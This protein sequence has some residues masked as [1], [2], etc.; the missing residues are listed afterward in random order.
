M[1]LGVVANPR[2]G[3]LPSVLNR[4]DRLATNHGFTLH[5]EESIRSL[6]SRDIP[7]LDEGDLGALVTLGGDGTL[8]RGSRLLE[9]WEIPILGVNVGRLGFLTTVRLG[10]LEE[11]L[12]A[13]RAGTYSVERRMMLSGSIVG[14]D[15]A[16]RGQHVALNDIA[17]HKSGVARV[18]RLR[19]WIEEEEIGP[20]SGDGLVIATPTG[21]TAY[22]LSAG[23]PI[24]VPGVEG[25]VV[26]PICAHTMAVRPLVV[27]GGSTIN[28]EPVAPWTDQ[29]MVSFDGQVSVDLVQGDRLCVRRAASSVGL[30][31]LPNDGFL[32]RLRRKLHWGD[33][34][35][36]D[37][38]T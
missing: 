7:A 21:S 6:W 4:L 25:M 18:I 32:T 22:S 28:I 24:M 34:M 38:D 16:G 13:L 15:G 5:S 3:D 10:E 9:G 23:G 12:E 29:L 1:R 27:S 8:L 36:R 2:Y 30:I 17:I 31:R 11:A 26:T 33:L 14:Q 35:E 19:V 20:I 37:D